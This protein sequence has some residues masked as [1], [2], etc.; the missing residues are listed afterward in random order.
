MYVSRR[1]YFLVTKYARVVRLTI[2]SVDLTEVYTL[3]TTTHAIMERNT[4]IKIK[5]NIILLVN[6]YRLLHIK[7]TC[8]IKLK[9]KAPPN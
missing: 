1:E 3:L 7:L 5:A 8:K 6:S 9:G 2:G 4:K